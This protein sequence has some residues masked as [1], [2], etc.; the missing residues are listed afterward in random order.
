MKDYFTVLGVSNQATDKEIKQAYRVLAMQ[1][2]PDRGGNQA[3]FQKIQEA[4]QILSDPQQRAQWEQS[5]QHGNNRIPDGVAQWGDIHA[6]F[7]HFDATGGRPQQEARNKDLHVVVDLPLASTV[8]AQVKHLSVKHLD[9]TRVTVAVEIPR[10]VRV[11][12]QMKY[13][14]YGNKTDSMLPAG[15]L[16]VDFRILPHPEFQVNGIDL[17]KILTLNC[18][19]A[20]TGTSLIVTG[21]TGT[22]FEWTVP[23][24]TQH[25]TKFRIASQGLWAPDQPIQGNLLLQVEISIPIQL[26]TEQL[27]AVTLLKDTFLTKTEDTQ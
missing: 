23:A 26:T 6:M 3:D 9:N 8:A 5:M 11:G 13:T 15:D 1:H 24:G 10:G 19:D 17:T 14:G 16:Y 22:Q 21:L 7:R 25:G 4:Y 2:H 27:D 20:I 18:L 12:M